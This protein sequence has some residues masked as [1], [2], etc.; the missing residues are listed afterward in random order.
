MN[1]FLHPGWLLVA[2]GLVIVGVGLVWALVP[3]I[4]WLGRLPGDV[5]IEGDH[6]RFYF[7]IVTCL[8]ISLVLSLLAWAF[9]AFRG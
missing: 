6:Y 8:L 4:P 9:R 5:R 2:I 7:P 3:S 1:G